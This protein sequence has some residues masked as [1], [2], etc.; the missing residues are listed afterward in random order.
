MA[1]NPLDSSSP[2]TSQFISTLG[3]ICPECDYNLTGLT[4]YRCPECGTPFDP[5]HLR[6]LLAGKPA[7]IPGWGDI[8]ESSVV[9]RYW[10]TCL[11]TWFHP[12]EF[13]RRFPWSYDSVSMARFWFVSK[14]LTV[15][16]MFFIVAVTKLSHDTILSLSGL[17]T[18]LGTTWSFFAGALACELLVGLALKLF[19]TPRVTPAVMPY[20]CGSSW[21]G[22]V[23]MFSS[24]Q[25]ISVLVLG[26]YVA[27]AS[28]YDHSDTFLIF[29]GVLAPM[30]LMLAW[31]SAALGAAVSV[32]ARPGLGV[33]FVR[34]LIP[35]LGVLSIPIG[36]MSSLCCI[37]FY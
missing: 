35:L 7:P 18:L 2:D 12:R 21:L 29:V 28:R 27:I 9:I 3:L 24:Y 17:M 25:L 19:A 14:L 5:E 11:L 1:T 16:L 8:D 31:W 37:A 23:F 10:R 20:D 34:I 13:A 32:H 33:L 22:L 36:A 26:T 4:E 15:L 30:G 6:E